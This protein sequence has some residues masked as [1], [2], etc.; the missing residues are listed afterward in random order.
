MLNKLT[1]KHYLMLLLCGFTVKAIAGGIYETK[2][3][4]VT[5]TNDSMIHLPLPVPISPQIELN[6]MAA[7]FVKNYIK[8][9]SDG[10]S[11][12]KER[13]QQYFKTI[14]AIF[15][16]YQIPLE[17]K[18]LAVVESKLNTKATSQV[19]AR[20]TWQLMPSTA[21]TL[22]L[23]I[24]GKVDERTHNYKST[25][26]AAKYLKSLYD[27]LGD[28]LLVIAAY[29]S[30][31]GT[32]YKAIK[33]AGSRDFWRLQAFLPAETRNHV[34]R[35]ISIHYYFEGEGSETT[36]TKAEWVSYQK[37]LDAYNTAL[38]ENTAAAAATA[39]EVIAKKLN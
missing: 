6:R 24:K 37:K 15:T 28:W 10:L 39:E 26:A 8:K 29:N 34:K 36:L 7:G 2:D 12:I 17:L 4:C 22:G 13:S 30:G 21:Q 5:L 27:D 9:N 19:G 33:K 3:S 1:M 32:I 16:Q 14:D 35:F 31:P 38:T 25:V 20:G 23:K 18:Y 11:R